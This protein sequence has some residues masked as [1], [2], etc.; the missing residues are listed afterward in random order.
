MIPA[1]AAAKLNGQKTNVA[2]AKAHF[3]FAHLAARLK[4][5]PCY[6]ASKNFIK[7]VSRSL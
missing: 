6:K 2:G 5:C 4:P 3:L 7:Q 1:S